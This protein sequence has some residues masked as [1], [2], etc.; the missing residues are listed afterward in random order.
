MAITSF[1][2]TCPSC[3]AAV[4]VKSRG[5]IGK[6]TDCPKCKYRFTVPDPDAPAG[7][8]EA[9]ADEAP[10]KK[11]KKGNPKVLVGV[12][13][14][15]GAV[16]ILAVGAIVLFGG[17][18]KP[19]PQPPPRAA[20]AGATGPAFSAPAPPVAG[21]QGDAATNPAAAAGNQNVIAEKPAPGFMLPG[22]PGA[23]APK[24][25]EKIESDKP[26]APDKLK[27]P[28]NLLPALT[29]AVL[30]INLDRVIQTPLY[31]AFFD[32]Q[33]L[34][35]F[36]TSMHFEATDIAT[37]LICIVEPDRE[38]FVV[39]RTKS[40]VSSRAIYAQPGLEPGPQNGG[41]IQRWSYSVWKKP[42]PFVSALSRALSTES[43]LGEAG[44][45]VTD[46]DKK[47]WREKP[48]GLTIYDSQ[49]LIIGDVVVLERFLTD[50]DPKTGDPPF[51]TEL[52]PPDA[53]PMAAA[54]MG[55]GGA[56]M[57]PGGAPGGAPRGPMAIAG[58]GAPGAAGP[59]AVAGPAVPGGGAA[60]G[61]EGQ[62]KPVRLYT[63]IPTYR[64]IKS[65]LK[66]ILNRL[67]DDDKSPPALVYA[68]ALDLRIYGRDLSAYQQIGL[69]LNAIIQNVKLIGFAINSLN[70]DKFH[71]TLL[72][73]YVSGEDAKTSAAESIIPLLSI[74]RIPLGLFF[75]TQ[76]EFRG[77]SGGQ[78]GGAGGPMA[79]AAPGVPGGPTAP[80]PG[81]PDGGGPPAPGSGRG[82]GGP[83]APGGPPG[84]PGG[85]GVPGGPG[86]PG[87]PGGPGGGDAGGP[88]GS[89]FDVS[90]S[91]T[92]IS[93]DISLEWRREQFV[94]SIQAAISSAASQL[95]GRMN[96]LSGETNWYDLSASFK[97][98]LDAKQAFPPG[99]MK[100]NSKPERYGLPYPPDH[101]ASF[102]VELLP[103]IGQGGLRNK[104]DAQKYAWYAKEN[105]PAAQTWVPE[106][107][108][109]YY[110]QTSW[111]AHSPLA[112]GHS[113][114]ATNY[115]ALSGLGLD[116]ARYDP[117]NPAYEKLV[118][119]TG[120]D[121]G[122]KP[123]QIKDGLSNTIYMIQVPPG[124][125]RPWIAGGGATVQGVDD[126]AA[127]PV[128]DFVHR[129]PDGKR[130]T[131]A[132]MA[133]GT[134]RWVAEGIDPKVFKAMVT[135]AG[136]ESIEL[137]KA[138]PK[139]PPPKG[140]EIEL[141]GGNN[142]AKGPKVGP[143][144]DEKWSEEAEAE[145]K[146]VQGR[147]ALTMMIN[148][149]DKTRL[150]EQQL[151]A[152]KAVIDF[153][154]R[155]VT[156]KIDGKVVSIDDLT[157]LDPK[158]SPRVLEMKEIQGPEPG[159]LT[160]AAYELVGED[161]MR[162]RVT[163]EGKSPPKVVRIPEDASSDGYF[164]MRRVRDQ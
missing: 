70:A 17:D 79:P 88:A 26:V 86:A 24:A 105:L 41:T 6:K 71:G 59:G 123:S 142:I 66:F 152:L 28:T 140:R 116:S 49:T 109:P 93:V 53:G 7:D 96:V 145:L 161:I 72:F 141:T 110:P 8:D 65:E 67:E 37:A 56:P 98:Q 76:I 83:A 23:E 147:W 52:T 132:L 44:L 78:Q 69:I 35:F 15:V 94:K 99:T 54:P 144:P 62:A 122:S 32:R 134:V 31:N 51:I 60:P 42:N 87:I 68:E 126:A 57:G 100:R 137:D 5:M 151:A 91:D 34:E 85:P 138:A 153:E 130:G 124:F 10:K 106:F 115:V 155:R 119:I 84:A 40:P 150:N 156:V 108:V 39:I 149:K 14:G 77:N 157:K 118:G 19:T 154:E 45:P 160:I 111:R 25:A 104:I 164:E 117:A 120:Y 97:K 95:K 2:V 158:A 13:L 3:E 50:L 128:M 4:P 43:L 135:R 121:W 29:T 21:G 46:E 30:R 12:L 47:R 38:P 148:P 129:T 73:Q 131:Y 146:K 18:D 81:S 82:R 16:V 58:P 125:N 133:D 163:T 27:D 101:R 63:S 92:L 11:T 107:L 74:V 103:F 113:L 1:T 159:K 75:G 127:N 61:S 80:G 136:G 55:P 143:T 102:L 33:M 48:L 9:P 22:V 162:V 139:E 89:S 112:E 20:T 64:T 90:Q 114:G 36:R